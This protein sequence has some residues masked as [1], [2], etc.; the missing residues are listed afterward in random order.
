MALH[1]RVNAIR[2][3]SSSRLSSSR[4]VFRSKGLPQFEHRRVSGGFSCLQI[5]HVVVCLSVS[6][7]K[8][9]TNKKQ[10]N[11]DK[12]RTTNNS[13]PSKPITRHA[14][15][16]LT[17]T[18]NLALTSPKTPN[19]QLPPVTMRSRSSVFLAILT[20]FSTCLTLPLLVEAIIDSSVVAKCDDTFLLCAT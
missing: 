18:L 1:Y 11:N 20:T 4:A 2:T 19:H 9:T 13:P 8:Q 12:Q 16:A 17:G 10:T 6:T 15:M 14:I 3:R 5:E 7:S